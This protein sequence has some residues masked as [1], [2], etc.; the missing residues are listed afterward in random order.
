M[1]ALEGRPAFVV[2][3]G[4]S[5]GQVAVRC[6]KCSELEYGSDKPACPPEVVSRHFARLGWRVVRNGASA[7][8]PRCL[9]KEPSDERAKLAA[10]N[11]AA[12]LRELERQREAAQ[13]R[14][15][16]GN[17]VNVSISKDA[18]RAQRL[19]HQ[20]LGE[21]FSVEGEHGAYDEGWDD[22]RVSTETG[23]AVAEVTRTRE[24]AYGRIVDPR[25]AQ[26]EAAIAGRLEKLDRDLGEL[27]ALGDNLRTEHV[28]A[29][30]ELQARLA[31]LK[32]RAA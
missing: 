12:A 25:I 7:T 29:L 13:R 22:R 19:L 16:N 6:S 26:L 5:R 32:G 15:P 8:C 24:A 1:R 4:R 30:Q 9:A 11:E 10:E 2:S 28:G 14:N 27:Q 17:E 21:H 20:L 31:A 18:L 23:L 3:P